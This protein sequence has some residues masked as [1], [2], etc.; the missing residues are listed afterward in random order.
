MRGQTAKKVARDEVVQDLGTIV[1]VNDDGLVVE[2]ELGRFRA[3]RA[4]SCLVEPELDDEVLFAGRPS[5]KL[6]VLAV[7]ERHSSKITVSGPGDLCVRTQKG[8]FAVAAAEGV[9]LVSSRDI[10]LTSNEVQVRASRGLMFVK[11]LEFLGERL[12]GQVDA[13]KVCSQKIERFVERVVDRV[14]RSY[15]FIEDADHVRAGQVDYVSENSMRLKGHNAFL[16]A[17]LLVK[18]E[19]DQIHLG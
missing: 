7:L 9:D 8:R 16:H 5:G 18:L 12:F 1:E 17:D 4:V 6:Y 2:S 19:G 14:K 11:D 13:V 10:S 15:R 3:V